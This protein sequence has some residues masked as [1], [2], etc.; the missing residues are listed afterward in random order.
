[1]YPVV[2][3]SDTPATVCDASGVRAEPTME[4]AEP[5]IEGAK[6]MIKAQNR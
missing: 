6:P 1:M 5:M 2:A 4:G 3:F